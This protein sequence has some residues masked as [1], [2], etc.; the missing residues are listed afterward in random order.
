MYVS[1]VSIH[2]KAEFLEPFL[3]ATRANASAAVHEP[4]NV[5]F[6]VLRSVEDPTRILLYEAYRDA[7]ASAAHKETAHYL[8]WRETVADWMAEPRWAA[9][10]DGFAPEVDG[11]AAGVA[12]EVD[13]IA[14]DA[15]SDPGAPDDEA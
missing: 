8:R 2:A 14:R 6:D 13:G 12:Q 9:L 15:D 3:E 10:Y 1:L 7:A 11:P 5:R 4:G